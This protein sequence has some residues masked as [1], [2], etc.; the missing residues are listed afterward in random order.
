MIGIY[1]VLAVKQRSDSITRLPEKYHEILDVFDHEKVDLLPLPR[2]HGINHRIDVEV[3]E[4]QEVKILWGPL[5][6]MLL[7]E[8]LVLRKILTELLH[9]SFG[10]VH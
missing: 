7:Y 5:Y 6:S 9:K 8:L 2:G 3:T 10:R 4:V 1:K